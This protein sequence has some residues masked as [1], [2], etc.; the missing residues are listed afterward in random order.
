MTLEQT[1]PQLDVPKSRELLEGLLTLPGSTGES[2]RRFHNYSP[3]NIGFLALQG[4]PPEPVATFKKWQE[5]GR[6][7]QR[8]E[9]A[10]SIL[11]PIQI[12]IEDAKTEQ[13]KLI[14]RFKVVRALFAVSQTDG[15]ELPAYEPP[16]WSTER[17]L[18][19]LGISLVPFQNFDGNIGGYARGKEIA[20]NPVAPFPL[21]TT[22][23]EISHVEHGHTTPEHL[24][25]YAGHRGTY[26]FEAEASA[27]V[28]LNEIGALDEQ[29]ATVSRGYVQGWLGEQ[30]PAE[31]SLRRVLNVSTRVLEAGY[32]AE[33]GD[34]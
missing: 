15:E 26:E 12:R 29:T 10:Y 1:R 11:R 18:G 30:E 8:G 33:E 32:A 2:Y 5:L 24:Q 19:K 3:R 17:A 7:V 28:T 13:V 21:R 20:I 6:Q 4:C 23:H 16:E 22:I 9:K 27:Y 34:Q 31:E 25:L 14:K